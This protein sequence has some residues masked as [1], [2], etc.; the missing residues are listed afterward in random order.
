MEE[1]FRIDREIAPRAG[2]PIA[3]D[4]ENVMHLA[5]N[6]EYKD[7]VFE[8]YIVT[9]RILGFTEN[10]DRD[11]TGNLTKIKTSTTFYSKKDFEEFENDPIIKNFRETGS[12][13]NTSMIVNIDKSVFDVEDGDVETMSG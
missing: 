9:K 3:D 10:S 2:G 5:N 7:Y 8:K 4:Y 13:L 1:R 6:Q 11:E 12:M